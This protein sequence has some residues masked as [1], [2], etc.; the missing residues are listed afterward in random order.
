MTVETTGHGAPAN[1]SQYVE[2]HLTNLTN[3]WHKQEQLVDFSVFNVDTVFFSFLTGV[4]GLFFLW[5]IA[6]KVTSGVPSRTQAAVEALV[7]MVDAQAKTIVHGDRSF[8][9]PLALT[10]F[11]WVFLM[12][13]M[14]WLP[15]DLPASIIGWLHLDIPYSRVVPTAD[16]NGTMGLALG[17]FV[18]MIYYGIKVKGLGGF[19]RELI[20]APFGKH[21]FLILPNLS[22]NLVEYFSKTLSLGIRLFGNMFAG[23]L[24]FVLIAMMGAA[25]GS[26]A[27]GVGVGLAF[28]QVVA[29]LL[30]A[31]FHVMVV[32]LQAFIFMM[33][34]LVY[35]GQ[36]HE[37]H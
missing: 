19:G 13:A 29:G 10:V 34:T 12:N 36:A 20:S 9:A 23:E 4:V 26:V 11:F 25:W 7:E 31:L 1:S 15:I 27:V 16:I 6:R 32:A 2:H 21:P 24:I 22:I 28:G 5:L 8:V 37:S 14:D 35:I 33:L 18:L 3:L 30:W 17:V